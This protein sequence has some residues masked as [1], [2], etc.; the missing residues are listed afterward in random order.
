MAQTESQVVAAELERVDPKVPVL[1]ER[2]A[3]FYANVEKRPVEKVSSRDMRIP[4]EIRPGGLFG[5]FDPAGGDLGR[6]EGPT[7]EKAVISTVSFKFAV[8]WHK[9]T[10]WSTDDSRKSVVDSVK[11]V[12]ANSMKEFRRAVDAQLQTAGDGILGTIAVVSGTGPYVL[13][14][15]STDGFGSRLLRVGHKVNIYNSTASTPRTTGDERAITSIDHENKLV[16]LAGGPIAGITAGDKIVASGLTG[17]N[18][19]GIY[20][21]PYH[22][23][24][25]SVGTWLGLDRATYPEIRANRI[26]AAGALAIPHARR[27]LNKIGERLGLEN[28][29]KLKAWMHPCQ[30]QAYEELGQNVSVINKGPSP[31]EK[32]DIYFDIQQIAGVPV[33][34]HFSWNKTRIDFVVDEVWGRAEMKPAGFYEEEGRRLFEVRGSSG[35]VAAATLFYL[36]ASF[37]TFTNQPPGVSYIDALTIPTGY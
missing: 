19:V 25:A 4:L 7:F 14:M 5:Y 16:S 28:G 36:V 22:H 13:T 18:P 11:H 37:N 31:T 34:K 8:E 33:K 9:K 32:M 30:A 27:A 6:G 24:N 23:N 20:G 2:D 3:M 26:N 1:F 10:Q 17:A 12:L 35:G 29:L 15:S 21:V